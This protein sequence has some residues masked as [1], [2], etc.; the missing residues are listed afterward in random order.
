MSMRVLVVSD[1]H[2]D[3]AAAVAASLIENPDVVLDCGDHDRIKTY[4]DAA[5]HF[6]IYGNH[7]PRKIEISPDDFPFPIKVQAGQIY[8]FR[9]GKEVLRFGGIDGHYSRRWHPYAVK[10][11][12]VALLSQI[13]EKSLDVFL[14]HESPLQVYRESGEVMHLASQVLSEIRRIKPRIVFSGHLNHY[15]VRDPGDGIKYVELDN[16]GRGYVILRKEGEEL[17]L[18]RKLRVFGKQP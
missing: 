5:P 3:E 6:Y 9:M 14:T 11:E 2:S 18:E 1:I 15:V 10:K 7:V 16:I 8:E 4:F 17:T 12:D 13:P